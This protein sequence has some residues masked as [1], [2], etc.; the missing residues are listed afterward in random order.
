MAS[1]NLLPTIPPSPTDLTP[2]AEFVANLMDKLI[3]GRQPAGLPCTP[4][5]LARLARTRLKRARDYGF[6]GLRGFNRCLRVLIAERLHEIARERVRDT[7]RDTR[8]IIQQSAALATLP[9]SA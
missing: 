3:A 2:A 5:L 7:R 4:A 8:R 6:V 9:V 1:P